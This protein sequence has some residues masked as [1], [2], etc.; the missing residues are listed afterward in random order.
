MRAVLNAFG[1]VHDVQAMIA[2]AIELRRAGHEAVLAS[3][4]D[5][6]DN[7][8]RHGIDFVPTGPR[9]SQE[10]QNIPAGHSRY[11]L[12]ATLPFLPEVCL[13]LRE[14]CRNADVLVGSPYQPGCQIVQKA[15]AEQCKKQNGGSSSEFRALQSAQNLP[16]H[17]RYADAWQVKYS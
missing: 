17:H 1:P 6:A 5:Y 13:T 16:E 9:I 11:F 8:R 4:P 12:E 15:E 7:A 14:T 10:I 3:S 2:L